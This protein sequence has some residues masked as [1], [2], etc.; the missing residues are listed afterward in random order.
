YFPE[1]SRRY[2]SPLSLPDAL[3][4]FDGVPQDLLEPPLNPMRLTLH[5]RGLAP[6]I[7]NLRQWRGHLLAQMER[8]IALRRSEPL[9]ALY[10]EVRSEE[11][12]SELQS[13]EKLVC[14]LLLE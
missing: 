9:R 3:P 1:P 11:H 13:R 2:T 7:R 6:R 10:E 12:T 5:P 14:R 4:I 8:H